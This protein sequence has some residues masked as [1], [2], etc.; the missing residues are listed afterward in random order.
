MA[1]TERQTVLLVELLGKLEWPLD[2]QVFGALM[3]KV[4]SVPIEL[5]VLDDKGRVLTFYRKDSGY[6]GHH[7]PGTVLR[8]NETVP[9]AL[10]R[11]VQSE[12]VG[13]EVTD[14]KNIGWV[15]IQKGDGPGQNPAR[16][17]TSLLFLCRI[18]GRYRGK[19]GVF[20]PLNRLP[21]NTLSH[22]RVLAAKFRKHLR[23]GKPIL[24]K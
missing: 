11:L 24:G 6:D 20:S 17:E 2:P 1:L 23:T 4:V 3:P 5:C 19:G 12:L 10:K 9:Q 21:E 16:H 7:M 22:H 13:G 14:P 18:R 15:E 8:N